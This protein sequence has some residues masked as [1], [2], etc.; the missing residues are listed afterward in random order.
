M[1]QIKKKFIASNA[2]D[3]SK[4]QLQTGQALRAKD[5]NGD[6]RDLFLF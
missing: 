4:I 3:G 2:I 1:S 5:Q 6:N